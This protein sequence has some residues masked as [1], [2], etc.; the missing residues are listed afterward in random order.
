MSLQS[1]LEA[2]KA[3]VANIES[4]IAALPNSI[5]GKTEDELVAI[6]HAITG[7]FRGAVPA[8]VPTD[9]TPAA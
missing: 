6:Y 9:T 3:V 2:A 4:E 7:Y 8:P 1:E 5:A